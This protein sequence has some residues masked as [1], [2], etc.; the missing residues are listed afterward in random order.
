[1]LLMLAWA[2]L[3]GLWHHSQW[4]WFPADDVQK[5]TQPDSTLVCVQVKLISEPRQIAA[6]SD[7]VLN[8]IP[9]SERTRVSTHIQKVRKGREWVAVSGQ[10]ELIVH[11]NASHLNSGDTVQVFGRLVGAGGTRNPG[12][13]DFRDSS[14][15]RRQLV[16]IHAFRS[17]GIVLVGAAPPLAIARL[18]SW[19]RRQ[20]NR[21]L[22]SHVETDR[23][24]FAS[25]ILLGNREQLS[26]DRRNQFLVTGTVHLLAISGLHIGILAGVFFMF[27]R[28]GLMQRSTALLFTMAFVICFAW[29]VEFRPPVMRATVLIVLFCLARLMG[30]CGMSYNLLALAALIILAMNPAD[31]FQ[32]GP[33]LSFLAVGAMV[34]CERWTTP[35]VEADPL[36]RLIS[37]TRSPTVRIAKKTWQK[38]L[39]AY[40]VSFLIG[41]VT[42]PLVALKFHL[43]VPVGLFLNPLLMLPIALALYAGLAVLFFGWWWPGAADFAGWICDTSLFW[44]EAFVLFGQKVPAAYFWTSGPGVGSVVV[45]YLLFLM[46]VIYPPTRVSGRWLIVACVIWILAGWVGPVWLRAQNATKMSYIDMIVV[47]TGHGGSVLMRLPKGQTVIYDAGCFG[48]A[49]YGVANISAV[50]WDQQIQHIDAMV[51]S[52]ADVDHFNSAVELSRRFSI[53]V[54]Y[55][56]PMM[57]GNDSPA[58]QC[59]LNELDRQGVEVRTLVGGMQLV[60]QSDQVTINVLGPPGHGTQGNDNSDSLVLSVEAMGRKVLLP[61]DLEGAGLSRLMNMRSRHFDLVMAPHH[62]SLNSQ[63]NEFAHWATPDHVVVSASNRR[64]NWQA[65]G[66]FE[67]AGCKTWVTGRDGAIRCRITGEGLNVKKW[68]HGQRSSPSFYS[69]RG[70][71]SIDK[72]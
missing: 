6:N 43:L 49:E 52:H 17:E 63:P 35:G 67:L 19:L 11:A 29:L 24:A 1:M 62:G 2:S 71:E 32:I 68:I 31:L 56:T 34:G 69:D 46:M 41:S 55:I 25:A 26:P 60:V 47:D 54:V 12:Q 44:I 65:I 45:F 27:F 59:L 30:R 10:A 36:K 4:N 48:S 66:E 15:S 50:L 33:Q 51:L 9:A 7:D 22:W 8:P 42:T 61:G 70:F 13:S 5:F 28:L 37:N 38:V 20:L 14:R 53:G 58:V 18:K 21:V 23:A 16:K 72:K 39:L 40:K 3:A 57:A 64:I